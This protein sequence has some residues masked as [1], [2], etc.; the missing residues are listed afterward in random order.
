MHMAR[1]KL[2]YAFLFICIIFISFIVCMARHKFAKLPTSWIC[3]LK[4]IILILYT[5]FVAFYPIWSFSCSTV[6]FFFSSSSS[7]SL[8]SFISMQEV[9]IVRWSYFFSYRL[10]QYVFMYINET[11]KNNNNKKNYHKSSNC[12][13]SRRK[14]M[15]DSYVTLNS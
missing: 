10:D 11:E 4:T 13:D 1:F 14:W 6:H 3:W 15:R 12:N 7:S 5:D 8:C 2:L 9:I